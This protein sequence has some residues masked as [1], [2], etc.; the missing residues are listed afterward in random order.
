MEQQIV[1]GTAIFSPATDATILDSAVGQN[2]LDTLLS[3][4]Q[5]AVGL[6]ANMIGQNKR[7][8]VASDAGQTL[9]MYNPVITKMSGKYS[10]EE[11]C[12]SLD[13]TREVQRFRQIEV[14]WQDPQFKAQRAKF[15]GF[16]AEIIQHEIDHTNGIV[17]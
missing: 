13:G 15:T 17:I 14:T 8:I 3:H 4:A 7:I 5:S 16:M 10:T 1:R 11:G 6:A 2:L 12:L 9:L